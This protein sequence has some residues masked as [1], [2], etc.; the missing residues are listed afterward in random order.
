MGVDPVERL[1]DCTDIYGVDRRLL[2]FEGLC[3]ENVS[4]DATV[5]D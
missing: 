4:L 1:Y 3:G 2:V 5:C